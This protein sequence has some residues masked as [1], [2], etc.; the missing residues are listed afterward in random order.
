MLVWLHPGGYT[1]GSGAAPGT[2]GEAL[3][4][5]GAVIVTINYRLGVLGFFSHP[6]LTKESDRRE[7][8]NFA[9]MDQTAA[10]QW[11]QK[12]IADLAAIRNASLWLAIRRGQP[13]SATLSARRAP[14]ACSNAPLQRAAHGSDFR[15][16]SKRHSPKR[17]RPGCGLAENLGASSLAALRAKPAADVLKG[18][19]GGPVIDGWFLPE[20]VGNIFEAGKQ[21]DVPMLLG[22]NK[23]EGTFFLQPTTAAKYVE[24]AHRRYGDLAEFSE[25]LSGRIGRRSFGIATRRIP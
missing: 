22:S 2:N 6:E 4:K 12:N 14:K 16:H 21:N 25:S 23:D 13:V 15:W 8:G 7:A 18:G 1:S 24:Q 17:N 9:F 11:V 10:L 3:A 19:R 5:K 20:D